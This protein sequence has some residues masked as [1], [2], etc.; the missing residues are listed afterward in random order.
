[1]D[2]DIYVKINTGKLRG[3]VQQELEAPLR[4][5]LDRPDEYLAAGR[6]VKDSRS[7]KA[8]IVTLPDGTKI[9]LK[10]YNNKSL[11]YTIRYLFRPM[12][13]FR[14]LAAAQKLK[15]VGVPTPAVFA[16]LSERSFLRFPRKAFVVNEYFDGLLDSRE[17]FLMLQQDPALTEHF[18][19]TV[20][21]YMA[22]MHNNGIRHGDLKLSNI[23]CR[24]TDSGLNFGIWDLDGTKFYGG[25]RI[26]DKY[27]YE[28]M[29]RLISSWLKLRAHFELP[30][31]REEIS[32]KFIEKYTEHSDFIFSEN[33]LNQRTDR[34]LDGIRQT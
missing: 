33:K 9:F 15:A 16:A 25:Q 23:L 19:A 32:R 8:G 18:A 13:P 14:V 7:T 2:N 31:D 28:E 17:Y 27:I 6:V 4:D 22:R 11:R 21:G 20:C 30:S 26:P 34:F 10:R 29:A 12:R 24:K 3:L 1:M 5:C